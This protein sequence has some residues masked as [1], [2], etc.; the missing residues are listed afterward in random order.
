MAMG[1]AAWWKARVAYAEP[2]GLGPRPRRVTSMAQW[3]GEHVAM[4]VGILYSQYN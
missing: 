1:Y 3:T 4:W 2:E